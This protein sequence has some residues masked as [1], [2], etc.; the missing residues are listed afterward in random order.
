M[1]SGDA[2]WLHMDRPTNHM[3]VNTI[4]W[5]DEPLDW[6]AVR[7]LLRDRMIERFPRFSQRF[8]PGDDG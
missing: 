3:I 5:F 6:D 7:T 1:D 2:A 8:I 4:M